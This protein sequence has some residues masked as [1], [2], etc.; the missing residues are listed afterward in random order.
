MH[1]FE[2]YSY[3]KVILRDWDAEKDVEVVGGEYNTY[4]QA[5]ERAK[6]ELLERK[7]DGSRRWTAVVKFIQITDIRHLDLECAVTNTHSMKNW[8]S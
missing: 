8:S 6:R 3:Y 2:H 7:E 4:P 1:Y 5:E